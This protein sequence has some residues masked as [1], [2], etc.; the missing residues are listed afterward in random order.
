M[1]FG[2]F[3]SSFYAASHVVLLVEI[4]SL[5]EFSRQKMNNFPY[6]P[7]SEQIWYYGKVVNHVKFFRIISIKK[8]D[9]QTNRKGSDA[10][11]FSRKIVLLML[12]LFEFEFQYVTT[13]N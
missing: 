12:G 3:S 7:F 1:T 10:T 5:I 4:L 6:R 8:F 2:C 11:L 13:A 9:Q